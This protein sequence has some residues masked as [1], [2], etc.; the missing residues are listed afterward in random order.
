MP[1]TANHTRATKGV[2]PLVP[3]RQNRR[4]VTATDRAPKT[5]GT[6]TMNPSESPR[7]DDHR[8]LPR[9]W[10]M[11]WARLSI[12][13]DPA[14]GRHVLWMIDDAAHGDAR[15]RVAAQPPG[16]FAALSNAVHA[17]AE[18]DP[19]A[20]LARLRAVGGETAEVPHI[21][22][23]SVRARG[24]PRRGGRKAD[25]GQL[26][27]QIQKVFEKLAGAVRRH[28]PENTALRILIGPKSAE[29][30]LMGPPG[31][32]PDATPIENDDVCADLVD[33]SLKPLA[34]DRRGLADM[35]WRETAPSRSRTPARTLWNEPSL[36]V[37]GA[38]EAVAQEFRNRRPGQGIQYAPPANDESRAPTPPGQK[39]A[40]ARS[41]GPR[42]LNEEIINPGTYLAG[43][44]KGW[45]AVD[46]Y[47]MLVRQLLRTFHA[48]TDTDRAA[49]LTKRPDLTG[50]IWDAVT[51]GTI[52]HAA[53]THGWNP[54]EWVEEEDRFLNE[55]A[56]PLH[57]VEWRKVAAVPGPWLRRGVIV[58]ANE[59]DGRSGD[60]RRWL[61][62]A[63]EHQ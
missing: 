26:P 33:A 28:R 16:G 17:L 3:V 30:F 61:D 46:L 9:G 51:A 22:I 36:V 34:L 59:L 24:T 21:E 56:G 14:S 48:G 29:Y 44:T 15:T 55:I 8:A 40:P 43:V 62:H 5:D 39:A 47:R 31:E 4:T 54:P 53:I 42:T 27:R 19:A 63:L 58:D 1:P 7:S 12:I 18:A 52:E 6:K 10:R 50:T 13:P 37:T 11:T 20:E 60:G 38:T 2:D 32:W 35:L 41:V 57:R 45:P 23:R 49:M 25:P